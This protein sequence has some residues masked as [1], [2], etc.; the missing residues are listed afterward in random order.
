MT[1]VALLADPPRPGLVLPDLAETSPLTESDAADLYAAL[2][3][4]IARAVE[5]SGGDLLV[6]Y[7]PDDLLPDEYVTDTASEAAVRAV[8][9]DALEDPSAARY[10]P[11][12]GSSFDARAGNTVTHL[13]REEGVQSVAVVRGSALFL[14]RT[15]VDSAAMKLR[16]TPTVLGPAP[17]GRVYYAA[18]AEDIDFDGAFGAPEV[19]TLTSRA[20][21]A[22]HG[23]DFVPTHPVVETGD[24]LLAALPTLMARRRADRHVPEHL[25]AWLG[26]TGLHAVVEDG[27][28]RLVRR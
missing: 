9:A 26:E 14:T 17:D 7:R 10:E 21:D 6:N 19:E 18:F 11:Q 13:L 1:V 4:D 28:S 25:A 23:V 27:E 3:K 16:S 12:V 2:L 5:R 15:V 8:V 20:L 24:D 22:G